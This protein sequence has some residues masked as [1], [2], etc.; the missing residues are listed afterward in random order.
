MTYDGMGSAGP[1]IGALRQAVDEQA[2]VLLTGHVPEN[3]PAQALL[4]QGR[5]T[6]IR[7]PTHPTRSE[8]RRCGRRL[9]NPWHWGIRAHP[10]T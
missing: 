10:K 3:T 9:E 5:A 7:L 2:A 1:S 4:E 8:N 6:W